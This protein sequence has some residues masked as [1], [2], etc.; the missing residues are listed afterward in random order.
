MRWHFDVHKNNAYN[1]GKRFE[2]SHLRKV[3][4]KTIVNSKE[5]ESR[6]IG[7]ISPSLGV[8]ENL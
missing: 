5:N 1:K 6:K 8:C 4:M 7:N 3:F 2:T